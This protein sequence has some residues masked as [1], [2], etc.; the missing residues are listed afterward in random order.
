[1]AIRPNINDY[2]ND[3]D[4]V[5]ACECYGL[6]LEYEEEARMAEE[7]AELEDS[8]K[9][10][11][12]SSVRWTKVILDEF[13]IYW[14]CTYEGVDFNSYEGEG[15]QCDV[16]RINDSQIL[17]VSKEKILNDFKVLLMNLIKDYDLSDKLSLGVTKDYDELLFDYER[18]ILIEDITE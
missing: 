14:D 5:V 9:E 17:I 12:N 1:M 18:A 3:V 13:A 7:Q 15:L 6:E 10:S 4:Y 11:N 16:V 8:E 2:E